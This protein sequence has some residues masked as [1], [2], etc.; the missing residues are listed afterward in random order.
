[1]NLAETV[2]LRGLLENACDAWWN[3]DEDGIV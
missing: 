2:M 1:M 3:I